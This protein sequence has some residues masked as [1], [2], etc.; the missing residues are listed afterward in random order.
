VVAHMA[1]VS[2]NSLLF[3]PSSMQA[4]TKQPTNLK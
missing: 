4:I 3:F 1:K 2:E